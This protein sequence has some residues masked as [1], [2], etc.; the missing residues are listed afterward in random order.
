MCNLQSLTQQDSIELN[1][2]NYC[3]TPLEE[4]HAVTAPN[5][6]CDDVGCSGPGVP[7]CIAHCRLD[8]SS[9]SAGADEMLF[10]LD[11]YT[12]GKAWE[13][14]WQMSSDDDASIVW[15]NDRSY[16]NYQSV[17]ESRCVTKGCYRVA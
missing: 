8:Y 7:S 6:V 9:C 15:E 14:S 17:V 5:A 4:C 12:D 1:C 13:T 2:S 11:I 16:N 3:G 10:Q